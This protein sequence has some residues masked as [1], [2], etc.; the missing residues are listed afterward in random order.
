MHHPHSSYNSLRNPACSRGP[1]SLIHTPVAPVSSPPQFLLLCPWHSYSCVG[2]SRTGE[3]HDFA[4]CCMM[5]YT[6][7]Q[8]PG[9]SVPRAKLP[10]AITLAKRNAVGQERYRRRDQQGFLPGQVF[11]L[12]AIEQA[13][14]TFSA[15]PPSVPLER[16]STRIKWLSE[17]P[18]KPSWTCRNVEN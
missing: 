4:P 14:R 13:S 2:R 18:G 9:V 6:P 10:P 1:T 17:P 8:N 12:Q 15:L 3:S 11:L 16:R 5:V 7:L